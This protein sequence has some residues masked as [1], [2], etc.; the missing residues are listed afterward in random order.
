MKAQGILFAKNGMNLYRGCSHGCIYCAFRSKCYHMEHA[1]HEHE[2]KEGKR[3]QKID[4]YYSY[5]GIADIPTDE[6][7]R[8]TEQ[9]YIQRTARQTA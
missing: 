4:I 7:M 9:E 2:K 3:T 8:K 6:E 1:I 5:V